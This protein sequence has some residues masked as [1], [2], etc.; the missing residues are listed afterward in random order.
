MNLFKKSNLSIS[1]LL[2]FM[3]FS[4]SAHAG[5]DHYY[6]EF[7]A[8]ANSAYD[9]YR[10]GSCNACGSHGHSS[11]NRYYY[12]NRSGSYDNKR[13]HYTYIDQ[14]EKDQLTTPPDPSSCDASHVKF[15]WNP[16]N[17]MPSGDG[18]FTTPDG[19]HYT[20]SNTGPTQCYDTDD[21]EN[22]EC[23]I[24]VQ[25]TGT[26]E[27]PTTSDYEPSTSPPS[28]P[29][30]QQDYTCQTNSQLARRNEIDA[31]YLISTEYESCPDYIVE[32][33]AY[34]NNDTLA[35]LHRATI[36]ETGGY[37]DQVISGP[38]ECYPNVTIDENGYGEHTDTDPTTDTPNPSPPGGTSSQ[39]TFGGGGD[40][41]SSPNVTGGGPGAGDTDG[42]GDGS[43]SGDGD[44]DGD[45]S[46][47]GDSGDGEGDSEGDGSASGDCDEEVEKCAIL[48]DIR[49]TLETDDDGATVD[50][51]QLEFD[52]SL[53]EIETG[54]NELTEEEPYFGSD[55]NPSSIISTFFLF[56]Q[57]PPIRHDFTLN[58]PEFDMSPWLV[59]P[60][61]TFKIE[62]GYNR[63]APWR[64]F[65]SWALYLLTAATIFYMVINARKR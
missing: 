45:G 15:S 49:D 11:G 5:T 34:H 20:E 56:P 52:E 4:I 63:L 62:D 55:F 32:Y 51:A 64:D 3:L 35:C 27:P 25:P 22:L 47:D 53:I 28:N 48:S 30:L 58:V 59:L 37:F 9:S 18:N 36:N 16:S 24:P 50:A 46:G 21:P 57:S 40:T 39:P 33:L 7:Q 61:F 31:A 13:W 6:Y 2:L 38:A 44:G 1:S 14:V 60:A 54:F 10:A 12:Q 19:C 17:S 65:M 26:S 8:Q 41:G 43:G 42:G 23:Y 29:P